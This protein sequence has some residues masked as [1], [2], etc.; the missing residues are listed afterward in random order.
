VPPGQPV[1]QVRIGLKDITPT[2]WRRLL[3]AGSFRI[4]DKVYGTQIDDYPDD[5]LD[6]N[7]VTVLQAVRGQVAGIVARP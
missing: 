2:I 6:E 5:E 3:V 4:G 1:V 7:D